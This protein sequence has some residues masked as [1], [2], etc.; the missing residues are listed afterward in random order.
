MT[1]D[2]VVTM[3]YKLVV[4][5]RIPINFEFLDGARG[6]F[7]VFGGMQN[8]LPMCRLC[9]HFAWLDGEDND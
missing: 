7:F 4:P 9:S 2:Q 3:K 8:V 5:F 6:Q 1:E